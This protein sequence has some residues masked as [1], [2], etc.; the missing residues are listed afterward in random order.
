MSKAIRIARHGGPE[1]LEWVDADVSAPGPGEVL[2]RQ[3]AVGLNFIDTYQRSGLYPVPLP[4]GLGQEAAGVVAAVGADVADFRIGDRAAYAGGPPGAYAEQRVIPAARLVKL[5][6]GVADE[7][8]AAVM[9]KGLTAWYLLRKTFP[10]KR[11][12]VL[13]V[14]AAAG[15]V[16]SVLVP[17]AAHLGA[18]VI[19]T[20]GGP[21]KVRRARA[22]GC[23][24]AIDYRAEDF[25][26]EVQRHTDGR[27][28]DV[29]YDSVGADTFMK[30]LD[31]LRPLGMMVSY[32]NASGRPPALDPLVLSQKGSLFLTRPTLGHYAARREELLNG[33][34]ALFH[35]MRSG[36]VEAEVGQRYAL[37]DAAIAHRD[38]ENR[39]TVGATVL[40]P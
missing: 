28:V 7:Q 11:G 15:G 13:L 4:S 38:L 26:A 33:A 1:V 22:L 25:V 34:K 23:A 5:P 3:T 36:V 10:V 35:V 39:K 24:H 14:H 31:C 37:K 20:A 16:G 40:L 17:W 12:D 29:V 9:L 2:L 6:R 21:D 8:A 19:G 27:G 32:G 18:T 30:S